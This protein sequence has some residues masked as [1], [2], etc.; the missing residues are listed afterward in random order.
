MISDQFILNITF[1]FNFIYFLKKNWLSVWFLKVSTRFAA[2]RINNT[3]K[4]PRM[5]FKRFTIFIYY[6]IWFSLLVLHVGHF[7]FILSQ[8]FIQFLRF[9][10]NNQRKELYRCSFSFEKWAKTKKKTNLKMIFYFFFFLLFWMCLLHQIEL[11]KIWDFMRLSTA[12]VN[13]EDFTKSEFLWSEEKKTVNV[14]G[15]KL[16]PLRGTKKN[17]SPFRKKEVTNGEEKN[18]GK[19]WSM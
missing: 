10:S 6:S 16:W 1:H 2:K 11:N 15:K 13:L 7:G 4:E 8:F 5:G 14:K 3:A 18:W 19:T 12:R 17:L 9:L